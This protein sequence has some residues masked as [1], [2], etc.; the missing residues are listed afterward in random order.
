MARVSE[1]IEDLKAYAK[2]ERVLAEWISLLSSQATT[3]WMRLIGS[4]TKPPSEAK[5]H[6][7][8]ASPQQK[9][10]PTTDS[11]RL[12]LTVGRADERPSRHPPPIWVIC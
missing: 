5:V 7:R 2:L 4:V 11:F 1:R 10:A 9:Q 8:A 3:C 12:R 6:H